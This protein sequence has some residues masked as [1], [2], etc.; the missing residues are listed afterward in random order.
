MLKKLLVTRSTRSSKPNTLT[1]LKVA[2]ITIV[3]WVAILVKKALPK[4]G[5][6]GNQCPLVG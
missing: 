6:M 1:T 2:L 5:K 4:Q 3:I